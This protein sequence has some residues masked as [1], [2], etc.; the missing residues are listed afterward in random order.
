MTD[1]TG[2]WR[3]EQW[4]GGEGDE[5]PIV[6]L[7]CSGCGERMAL[8]RCRRHD[9]PAGATAEEIARLVLRPW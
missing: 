4:I 8:W 6:V 5:E 1:C 7:R 3:D 9:V 2:T